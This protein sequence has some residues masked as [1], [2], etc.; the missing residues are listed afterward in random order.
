[1]SHSSD[2]PSPKCWIEQFGDITVMRGLR[3]CHWR[4]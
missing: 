4:V 3:L 2:L 1:L